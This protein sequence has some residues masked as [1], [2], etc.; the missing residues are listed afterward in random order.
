MV[1]ILKGQ[2]VAC[3]AFDVGYEVRLDELRA[4][5]SSIPVQPLSRKKQT[6][7]FLQYRVP[8]HVLELGSCEPLLSASGLVQATVFDFGAVSIAYK[9]AL[10]S[11]DA[12]VLENLPVLSRRVYEL[13]LL[14]DARRR[15][16][17]LVESIT[18]VIIRPG[19]SSLVE[20][21]YLFIL[22]EISPA[23][24]AAAVLKQYQSTLAQALSFE[25]R[26]LSPAQQQESLSE[27]VSYYEDDLLLVD[28]NA[29]ILFDRDYEDIAQVVEL[30]NV[31]LLEARYI[32]AQLDRRIQDYALMTYS[33][34]EWPIPLR[35]PFRRAILDLVE[36]RMESAI[37][38]ER[39]DN[40]LKLVGDLYLARVH[41][42][43]ARR[44]YL[45]EW[46]TVISHKLDV[47]D[48]F[49]RLLTDRLRTAQNQTLELAI[50]VLICLELI[51]AFVS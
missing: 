21:Y 8:P 24:T 48:G 36:L 35:T 15:V 12:L 40:A 42:A 47:L 27:M 7:S 44:C 14:P 45:H 4:S 23:M 41:T 19:L 9:W 38:A 43:A 28:W 16:E 1:E 46:E 22:E 32:D 11:A 31:E 17:G 6:P 30:L 34:T 39:V 3:I 10:S 29:A 26:P 5:F 49:Y 37:L 18:P 20:D 2:I 25:T 13:D 33:H 51:L 50:I